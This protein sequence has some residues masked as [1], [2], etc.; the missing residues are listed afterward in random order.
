MAKWYLGGLCALACALFPG[1]ARAA[2]FYIDPINGSASGDGSTGD[3][4]LT[5]EQ[6][7]GDDLIETRNWASL[8]PD[9]D[10]P[11][12]VVNAGAPVTAGDTLWL[13]TGYH[14]RLSVIG[15]YNT[16]PITI[17]AEPDHT[18]RLGEIFLRSAGN[19]IIDGVSVSS[20]H[21]DPPLDPGSLVAFDNHGFSGPSNN[22]VLRN[23]EVFTVDDTSSWGA[24]EWTNTA[25][26]GITVEAADSQVIDNVIRNVRFGISASGDGALISGNVVDGVSADGIRGLGNNSA[27]E[28]NRVQNMFVSSSQGDGNHDD[29]FQ[30]W[31][32]GDDGVGTGEV[33]N[34]I[35]RG[36]TFINFTDPSNPLNAPMQGIGCFDG[37]F[38]NWTVENNVVI[39]NHWHGISFYGMQDSRIVN[40][41]VLDIQAGQPG[42]SWIGVFSDSDNVLIRN[43]LSQT[44]TLEGTNIAEDHNMQ[45]ADAGALF[46]DPPLD[47]RLLAGAAAVDAGS[48]DQA[49]VIDIRG[50]PRPWG[51]AHDLGAYEFTDVLHADGFEAITNRSGQ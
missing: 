45:I 11:L 15:A 50:L 28:Y 24:N 2:D 7:V 22:L 38:V 36:N 13:R 40:N 43:N 25:D 33:N 6:V 30:S 10:T 31:S 39:T 12:V 3:P 42:P 34:V 49:P 5:L 17:R 26:S 18:P 41:T 47:V 20:H 35:L 21:A 4:W 8:P 16:A 46:E 9:E 37:R 23:S 1:D 44:F 19:W 27:Y 32:V 29:G 14:G 51:P 48:A